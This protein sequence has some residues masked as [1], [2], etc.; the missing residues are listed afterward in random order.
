MQL[1]QFKPQPRGQQA[2]HH[3]AAQ[4]LRRIFSL[5]MPKISGLSCESSPRGFPVAAPGIS[6]ILLKPSKQ[7]KKKGGKKTFCAAAFLKAAAFGE[8]PQSHV[9]HP[10]KNKAQHSADVSH[11]GFCWLKSFLGGRY[12]CLSPLSVFTMEADTDRNHRNTAGGVCFCVCVC[13]I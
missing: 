7:W 5:K 10:L 2:K 3:W 1:A 4:L 11:T 12:S 6:W 9:T 8:I 13:V